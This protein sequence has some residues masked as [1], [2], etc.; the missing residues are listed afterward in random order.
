[1][2]IN[3][4]NAI[5]LFVRKAHGS[6]LLAWACD[7]GWRYIY[8]E[9]CCDLR[10][11]MNRRKRWL[12]S[13][14]KPPELHWPRWSPECS[15]GHGN[16]IQGGGAV[17]S[18]SSRATENEV[19]QENTENYIRI[20]L[21]IFFLSLSL[22][23]SLLLLCLCKSFSQFLNF[24]SL[25]CDPELH[26]PKCLLLLQVNRPL[27]LKRRTLKPI[28]NA[29]AAVCCVLT[30]WMIT[31]T[32]VSRSKHQRNSKI[33]FDLKIA[34]TGLD[35]RA[36]TKVNLQSSHLNHHLKSKDS[37]EDVIQILQNLQK[38]TQWKYAMRWLI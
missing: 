11:D 4:M 1:M 19:E 12:T 24:A 33:F 27:H 32:R 15:T 38:Q 16:K 2:G 23:W 36:Q 34:K 26:Y 8:L 14:Q 3:W 22:N 10:T 13:R 18:Q 30:F 25:C 17:P 28:C 6:S 20:I 37:S 31:H 7:R 21:C 29:S 5:D 9:S 35:F